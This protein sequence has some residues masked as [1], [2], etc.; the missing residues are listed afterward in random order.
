MICPSCGTVNEPGRKFCGECAA[1]L[2]AVC[3]SC[4]APNP[5][6][7]KFCGE[8]GT[9]L[10]AGAP[11]SG[12]APAT[13][14]AAR[15]VAA[16]GAAYHAASAPVAERRLVSILFAD[17]VGFTTLAEGRDPEET[18]ELL[19][20][21][22]DLSRDIVGRYGGTI[23][24]FI[25]DAVMAVWG[26]PTT[27]EDDAERAVRAGLELVDAVRALGPGI[28]ARA[29][30]LTGEAAVTIGAINQGMVAGDLVN[31]ASRLQSAAAPG[32]VLV[33]EATQRAAAAAI[34]FEP[35]GEQSLK[36]KAAP[37]PAWVA[38][39]VVAERGGRR[40]ADT[41]EAPF[42]GRD[43]ELRMLKDLFHATSRERR[44][45]LVSVIGPAGIGK[46]RLAWEF[47]KYLDGLVEDV[48]WHDGRSPAYGEGISFW[49]LGEMVRSRCGLRESDDTATTRAK[50]AATLAEHVPDPEDRRW[51]EPALLTLL[52]VGS[53]M[54]S[55][56]LFGAWRTF[57]E[58]LAATAPVV[59]VFE[60][61]HHADP[62]LLDF[63]DH[64]LDFVDHLLEWSRNH[65]IYVVTLSRPELLDRRPDWGA[66]KR[67]FNSLY[68]E[69]LPEPAMRRLLAGLV[70][71]L[72][73]SAVR[74]IV[75]RADGVPLYAVETVRMLVAQGR[76]TVVDGTYRPVGD[77]TALAVPETLTA[78][79]ASR[80]DALTPD[81]RALVSDAAVLGQSFTIAAL[82]A[83]SG[84]DGATLE[85]RLRGL[86]RRELLA[87]EADPR[88]PEL[89]QYA[90]VQALI[91]EVAYNT[92]ARRDRK[93][94]HLAA[95]R[96]FE[97]VG[98]DELAGALA[99]HY[100][101]AYESATEGP[102]AD[103]LAAQARVALSAAAE[104]AAA[105]GSHEQAV[106]FL[107]QALTVTTDPADQASL[108]E[109]A[110]ESA[111]LAG[112]H[113]EADALLV[114][115]LELRRGLGDRS[116]TARTTAALG[117]VRLT[118]RR[119]AEAAALLEPAA[120]EFADL[121]DA[122]ALCALNGQ[123]ARLSM[124]LGDSRR[125]VEMADRALEV[126]EHADLLPLLADILVTK[127][128]ALGN[129]G[130]IHEGIG[131]IETGERLARSNGYSS[132]LLRALNNRTVAQGE[133]DPAATLVAT[134]EGLAL[135]RRLGVRYWVFN[136]AV[137][138]GYT[139]FQLGDWD[140][141][142]VSYGEELTNDP[143]PEDRTSLL[144]NAL[145]VHALRGE[146]VDETLEEIAR[147]TGDSSDRTQL[148]HLWDSRSHADLA[149]FRLP[150]A[151]E[152]FARAAEVAD[153]LS[154]TLEL[155]Q[156]ARVALWQGDASAAADALAAIDAT[157]FHTPSVEARRSTIRAGLAALAGRQDEAL[158]RYRDALGRFRGLG[159]AFDEALVGL[160]MAILLDPALPDVVAAADASREILVRLRA[161]PF[162]ERLDAAMER[163]AAAPGITTEA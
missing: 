94:R 120:A 57:F 49:A 30:V 148:G 123:A 79:I 23:E 22:F 13:A 76:L 127:G 83:V 156:L 27:H 85:P 101:A 11:P 55:E 70:P 86:V 41:L 150:E 108:L 131:V 114:R 146:P 2:I 80:L 128:T 54:G 61:Q 117:R 42:V 18:R 133:I 37:V 50:V 129:I 77:L 78:L 141:A 154:V 6:T 9:P 56:Q 64:L 72:P 58:R 149:A 26:A 3:P 110:G 1:R 28:T 36:G 161:Q 17:L 4:G 15:P 66:G 135:A 81:D 121:T 12:P 29:G 147:L 46:S 69:P 8:C 104:R 163:T 144:A 139:R 63:V 116:A 153:G 140:G 90:F 92:L 84:I 20:R 88:S 118:G 138:V 151:R 106:T 25:G 155:T 115:G 142:L 134:T 67:N 107:R 130:R 44:A 113:D 100:L 119:T 60:D 14:I 16:P 132:T 158:V 160:D 91:R 35:A 43:D 159:F 62:G 65:P 74:V 162:V 24:K 21:Y 87:L 45:R 71:G 68:L 125:C 31:T 33:G 53:G 19:T 93:V 136:F 89:G 102:E 122:P 59:M 105:L 39:R 10:L 38:L 51:I 143:D 97:G 103:A 96:F 157:G 99:G 82:S 109:R 111:S 5:P 95:A 112:H 32:T 73:E 126:A 52:G 152:S 48:W 124:F 40:R 98:S 47:T 75:S 34:A 145:L 137:S 7:V